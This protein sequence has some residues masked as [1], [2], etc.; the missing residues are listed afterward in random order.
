MKNEGGMHPCY[1]NNPGGDG[2]PG[3]NHI[4]PG[5]INFCAG[6]FDPARTDAER[7]RGIVHE[8]LHWMRNPAGFALSDAHTHCHGGGNC[9]TDKAYHREKSLHLSNYD[10]GIAGSEKAKKRRREKHRKLA[11]RNNDN[12]AYF[13]YDLGNAAYTRQAGDGLP[14]LT[15]FPA[16]GFTW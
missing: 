6:F 11:W 16:P 13:I 2:P 9:D 4:L 15:Q 5:K 12:Y 7:G 10:G 3:A 8:T 14:S 1:M